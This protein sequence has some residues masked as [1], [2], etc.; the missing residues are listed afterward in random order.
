MSGGVSGALGLPCWSTCM[1]IHRHG[2]GQPVNCH[3][4]TATMASTLCKDINIIRR[5]NISML[6]EEGIF[7]CRSMSE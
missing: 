1:D 7:L 3:L 6:P 5:V 4:S 2:Q